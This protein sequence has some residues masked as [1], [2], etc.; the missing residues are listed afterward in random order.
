MFSHMVQ[1]HHFPWQEFDEIIESRNTITAAKF[2]VVNRNNGNL[3]C[4]ETA[5]ELG[6]IT[7]QNGMSARRSNPKVY[8][9]RKQSRLFKI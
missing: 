4:C 1:N 7:L 2:H 3:I 9:N 8:P 6:L 5:T